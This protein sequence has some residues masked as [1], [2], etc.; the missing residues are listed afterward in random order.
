FLYCLLFH[1]LF[2]GIAILVE[3]SMDSGFA[4]DHLDGYRQCGDHNDDDDD[5]LQVVLEVGKCLIQ[6]MP[7]QHHGEHPGERPHDIPEHE[8]LAFHTYDTGYD[9]RECTYH[10]Q[11]TRDENGAAAIFI[12]KLL[13]LPE[14]L[15]AEQESIFLFE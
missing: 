9:G 7:R 13:G 1:R 8:L 11:E 2:D 10:R 12:I 6:V 3:M 5:P 14:V 4:E 15:L